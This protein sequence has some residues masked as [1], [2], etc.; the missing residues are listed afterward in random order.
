MKTTFASLLFLFFGM[1]ASGQDTITPRDEFAKVYFVKD[2]SVTLIIYD[3][4]GGKEVDTLFNSSEK[5]CWYLLEIKAAE[6]GWFQIE[7]LLHIPGCEPFNIVYDNQPYRNYW[8]KSENFR[9]DTQGY[10]EVSLY[11]SPNL[12]ADV[13]FKSSAFIRCAVLDGYENWLKVEFT[14]DNQKHIG[15]LKSGDYCG[16]PWTTCP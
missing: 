7:N 11:A 13:L 1:I 8:V 16:Y 6:I 12:T 5:Y 4:A 10:H 15:W 2:T 9:V 3:Q 14:L